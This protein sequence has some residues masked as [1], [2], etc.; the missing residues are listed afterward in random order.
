MLPFSLPFK[1]FF[2]NLRSIFGVFYMN[3]R[4]FFLSFWLHFWMYFSSISAPGG[5]PGTPKSR[6]LGKWQNV[7][8]MLRFW[9]APWRRFSIKNT[10]KNRWKIY[11]NFVCVPHRFWEP[12]GPRKPSQNH[13]KIHKKFL[14]KFNEDLLTFFII[15][16]SIL[17]AKT[18]PKPPP[19]NAKQHTTKQC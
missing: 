9:D 13:I 6:I 15:F 7:P 19:K 12:K 1:R 4:L 17:E 8:K 5:T 2:I 16:S 10:S 14:R 11:L 18:S 3:F